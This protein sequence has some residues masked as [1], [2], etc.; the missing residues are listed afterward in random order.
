MSMTPL[1]VRS[2]SLDLRSRFLRSRMMYSAR[3][4]GVCVSSWARDMESMSGP[5][6]FWASQFPSFVNPSIG[7]L[8]SEKGPGDA[9]P[10]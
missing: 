5:V 3:S 1:Y 9:G 2:S 4:L 10:R 8:S 7:F 6:N